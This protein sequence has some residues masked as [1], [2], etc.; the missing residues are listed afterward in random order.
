MFEDCKD[1]NV[2][3]KW[4]THQGQWAESAA[5]QLHQTMQ[6]TWTSTTF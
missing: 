6:P 3:R 1:L 4:K 2:F 5:A